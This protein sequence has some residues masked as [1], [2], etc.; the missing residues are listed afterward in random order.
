M[1]FTIGTLAHVDAGKTTFCEQLLYRAHAIRKRGRVDHADA[2]LDDHPLERQ[3]G[4]TIFSSQASF[5]L[6]EHLCQIVDTPGHADFSGEMER[7]LMVLDAAVLLVS[8]AEGIQAHTRTLWRLLRKYSIPTLLFLNKT[9][10]EGADPDALLSA[11]REEFSPD[12]ADLRG[13]PALDSFAEEVASRDEALL[14]SYLAGEIDEER[15]RMA[16][17]RLFRERAIFPALAGSAL[18]DE[19]VAEAISLLEALLT[20]FPADAELADKPFSARVYKVRNDPQAGRLAFLRVLS[21]T[22]SPR[23]RIAL[24]DGVSSEKVTALYGA[25]GGKLAP[26]DRA[27]PGMICAV[28]GISAKA[29]E[30]IGRALLTEPSLEPALLT[31]VESLDGMPPTKLL[32]LMR[33]LEDEDPLLRVEWQE[34]TRTISVRVMGTIQLEVLARVLEERFAEKARFGSCR[35]RYLET[36]EGESVGVGHYEPLRH[37]AE[38]R[39]LLLAAP[40]GSGITFES[41]CH[42]DFLPLSWQNQIREILLKKRH[43]GVLTGAELTDVRIVLLNGRAHLK[44]TEGGDF[45]EASIRAVRN[46]LMRGK[47]VLLEPMCRFSLL[48]PSASLDALLRE[49]PLI[50]ARTEDVRRTQT[51]C[52]IEG[53]APASTLIPFLETLPAVTHGQGAAQWELCGYEPCHNAAEVA[54]ATAYNPL[55]DGENSP[56]SVFCAKGA[57]FAVSWDHVEEWAH[58]DMEAKY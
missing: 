6:G 40:R 37:Y 36:I 58:T 51:R 35:V 12:I 45:Y 20:R 7:A 11:L 9:D 17:S 18:N 31:T 8:C 21:G 34:S 52:E 50:F 24:G 41:R 39:V 48:A 3:R 13:W 53:I 55:A 2:F 19:G 1:V 25:Q 10:R 47:S 38:T 27:Q 54:E 44:H 33:I 49:L 57:G 23:D 4:I 30:G 43:A 28:A 15:N 16:L 14:E 32:A 5:P 42:V 46:A 22:V 56:N 26:I 29:G